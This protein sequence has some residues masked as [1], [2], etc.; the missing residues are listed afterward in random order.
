[1]TVGIYSRG[2]ENC[3]MVQK[4]LQKQ[5]K[6]YHRRRPLQHQREERK[7]NEILITR[8]SSLQSQYEGGVGA[9]TSNRSPAPHTMMSITGGLRRTL[10]S[11]VRVGMYFIQSLTQEGESDYISGSGCR[12]SFEQI[13][14]KPGVEHGGAQ[15]GVSTT[16]LFPPLH[17]TQI[18][19]L[20]NPVIFCQPQ[21]PDLLCFTDFLPTA[22]AEK[23]LLHPTRATSMWAQF[24][25]LS[26]TLLPLEKDEGSTG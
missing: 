14:P 8:H 11:K 9:P 23:D 21:C 22:P 6:E 10:H 16:Y 13:P 26:L 24:L 7:K 15:R 17:Q 5:M 4:K 18:Q 1:M 2:R 12:E 25:L 3:L 20:D 19:L